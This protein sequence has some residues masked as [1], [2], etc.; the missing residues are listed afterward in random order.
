MKGKTLFI[1][2]GS[3]L[4]GALA[5]L[6]LT[7][8][9]AAAIIT[10]SLYDTWLRPGEQVVI[11]KNKEFTVNPKKDG[12]VGY[13]LPNGTSNA[14]T[15]NRSASE[16]IEGVIK[17][18]KQTDITTFSA[19]PNDTIY[20]E[21]EATDHVALEVY[22]D[23]YYTDAKNLNTTYVTN[24][25]NKQQQQ[26]RAM[27]RDINAQNKNDNANDDDTDGNNNPI[28]PKRG[29]SYHRTPGGGSGRRWIRFVYL[30]MSGSG[31]MSGGATLIARREKEYTISI[32]GTVGAEYDIN[33]TYTRKSYVSDDIVNC[34]AGEKTAFNSEKKK[35]YCAALEMTS[36]EPYS[37]SDN[38]KNKLDLYCAER[39]S[40]GD[41]I[42]I[43]IIGFFV[44]VVII[45][46][47]VFFCIFLPGTEC[48]K[49]R[50]DIEL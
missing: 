17:N 50:R 39:F 44:L 22:L 23:I 7:I 19:K 15:V 10:S 31:F 2:S 30:S 33:I 13:I 49:K 36:D 18:V 25:T 47:L 12:V 38:P 26:Q 3:V 28:T 43:S 24:D 21:L 11:C 40:I 1:I 29:G 16:I 46:D 14:L 8:G 27:Y 37:A 34:T 5:V 20:I 48:M 9:L 6:G 45:M 41:I 42:A 4:I 32:N 35:G